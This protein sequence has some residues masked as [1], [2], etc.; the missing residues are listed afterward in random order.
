[1]NTNTETTKVALV[2][3]GAKRIGREICI[4][5]HQRGCRI[6]LHYHQSAPEA[7]GL[8]E[9]LN[10][11]RANSAVAL[12]ASLDDTAAIETLAQKA[13]TAFG[14]VDILINN[15]SRFYPDKLGSITDAVW[16]E[17]MGSNLKAPLFL[18]QAL[19]DSLRKQ[20]GCIINLADIYAFNPLKSH[21]VYSIAKAG[22]LM[23]TRSLALELSPDVRVN[24]VCPGAI[25][26]PENAGA[27]DQLRQQQ[28][29]DNTLLARSGD[30]SDI[31]GTVSFL[32]LD[33]PFVNNQ[34]I[35]VDGGRRDA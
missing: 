11:L 28:I 2:T 19:A 29:L 20:R 6:I 34:V 7:T 26:W 24:S 22:N 27:E 31:A 21:T 10:A 12:Q 16:D 32:A 13:L 8:C 35:R 18:A 30:V 3:G 15:A 4:A 17:L 33:A 14:Q 5:L 23:L 9:E 1:M 25:L